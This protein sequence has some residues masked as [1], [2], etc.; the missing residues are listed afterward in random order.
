M[1]TIIVFL[2]LSYLILFG[3]GIPGAGIRG[4]I[5]HNGEI[6]LAEAKYAWQ[7]ARGGYP[8][9]PVSCILIG[10]GTWAEGKTYRICDVVDYKGAKYACVKAH[11]SEKGSSEPVHKTNWT[12]LDL[13]KPMPYS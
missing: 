6:D 7:V 10:K 4:D 5:D 3:L 11:R 13:N 8:G 9:L 2:I 1:K 12:L